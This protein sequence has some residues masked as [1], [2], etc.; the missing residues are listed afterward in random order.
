MCLK[1]HIQNLSQTLQGSRSLTYIHALTKSSCIANVNSMMTDVQ[2]PGN[3]CLSSLKQVNLSTGKLG[4]QIENNSWQFLYVLGKKK[5]I[6]CYGL[7]N[8]SD[9]KLENTS[10]QLFCNEL[11]CHNF[12][13]CCYVFHVGY[14]FW[15]IL[16]IDISGACLFKRFELH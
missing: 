15:F 8:L 13:L 6:V 2:V 9:A 7:F 16:I 4:L 1:L 3:K 12:L 14:I 10:N 11:A 5:Y